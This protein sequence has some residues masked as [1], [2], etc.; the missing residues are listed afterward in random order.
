MPA[1]PLLLSVLTA[2]N[3][4]DL[5]YAPP[6]PV[7]PIPTYNTRPE[8]GSV[9]VTVGTEG[10]IAVGWKFADGSTV[11][12]AWKGGW[13]LGLTWQ[14]PIWETE[15]QRVSW[16]ASSEEGQ[17]S[18]WEYY[19]GHRVAAVLEGSKGAGRC[20]IRTRASSSASISSAACRRR[21]C[22]DGTRGRPHPPP[23]PPFFR[24]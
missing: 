16:L 11:E 15:D 19:L 8:A 22:S 17:R 9:F 14:R 7:L 20:G 18:L 1:W 5:G 2:Q 13:L 24:S 6:D 21:C 10:R 12:A 23:P 3:P 4:A